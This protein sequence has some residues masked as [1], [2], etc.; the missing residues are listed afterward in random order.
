[1]I[2]VPLKETTILHDVQAKF[3]PSKVILK[4]ASKGHGM[5]AGR[6]MRA[7]F[8]VCGIRDITCKCLGSTNPVNV[9]AATVK[10]LQKIKVKGEENEIARVES[11]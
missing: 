4:P 10:A 8:E 9:V 2:N 1:M 7:F 3:G 11:S 6:A 5:V